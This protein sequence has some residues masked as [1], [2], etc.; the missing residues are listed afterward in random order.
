[1]LT[2][3]PTIPTLI[4]LPI[5]DPA[6]GARPDLSSTPAMSSE[7]LDPLDQPI[8]PSEPLPA[9]DLRVLD[10]LVEHGFEPAALDGLSSADRPRGQRLL[11]QLAILDAYPDPDVSET[12]DDETLVAATMARI[13]R[14]D[15]ERAARMKLAPLDERG[16]GRRFRLGDLIAVASV[17]ILAVTVIVPLSS[18]RRSQAIEARCAD[19][20]RLVSQGLVSYGIDHQ[21]MPMAASLLPDLSTWVGYRNGDNLRHLAARQ[22]CGPTCLA[23]PGDAESDS[24]YALEVPTADSF[25]RLQSGPRHVLVGDRNPLVDLERHGQ[26][27]GSVALNAASHEGR[28]QNLLFSDG[29][30]EFTTSPFMPALAAEGSG[31]DNIWLPFG[32]RLDALRSPPGRIP[33]DTFLLH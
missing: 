23:C 20:L 25:R 8:L 6:S 21:A 15:D 7:P 13:E 31:P 33:A 2:P 24:C 9:E 12:A 16:S 29:A 19:N 5:A 22:Y 14:A 11:D 26:K 4:A 27:V 10:Y 3:S 28:G 18:A 17:A 1:M 30:V 32:D